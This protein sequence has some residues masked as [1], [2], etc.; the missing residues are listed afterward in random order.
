MGSKSQGPDWVTTYK[1]YDLVVF[2][3][4]SLTWLSLDFLSSI[5]QRLYMDWYED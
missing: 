1:L 4:C 2:L 5:K 3:V